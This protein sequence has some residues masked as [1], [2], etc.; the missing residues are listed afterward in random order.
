VAA[1]PEGFGLVEPE[2]RAREL[3]QLLT[4]THRLTSGQRNE[5][6]RQLSS[7]LALDQA[8][9]IIEGQRAQRPGCP[10]CGALHGVRNGQAD[11]MQRYKCRGC[12]VTFN[13][14]TGTPLARMRHR[15]KWLEQAKALDRGLSVRRAAAALDVHRTTAFR[16]RRRFVEL[17]RDV[18][19]DKR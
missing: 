19:A 17:P 6:L 15:D 4:Q 12:G 5:L 10:K 8:T 14:L 16:W 9:T 18:K 1:W 2:M 13:A 11:G 7:G 3:K